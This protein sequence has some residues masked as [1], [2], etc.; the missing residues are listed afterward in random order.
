MKILQK[1]LLILVNAH[2]NIFKYIIKIKSCF[3]RYYLMDL[4]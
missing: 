1:H 3:R 4:S 2:L